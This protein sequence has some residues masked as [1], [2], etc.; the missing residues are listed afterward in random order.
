MNPILV[1]ADELWLLAHNLRVAGALWAA[2]AGGAS[3]MREACESEDGEAT[4]K[5]AASIDHHRSKL[6]PPTLTLVP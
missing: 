4:I 5:R 6:R 1:G 3:T 2:W